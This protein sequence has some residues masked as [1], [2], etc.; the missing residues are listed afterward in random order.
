MESWDVCNITY[1]E[2]GR[3]SRRIKNETTLVVALH[4]IIISSRKERKS[5]NW[6]DDIGRKRAKNITEIKE[7]YSIHG[8]W[9]RNN[10]DNEAEVECIVKVFFSRFAL[11]HS[12]QL[13]VNIMSGA[14]ICY[15]IIA[16]ISCAISQSNRDTKKLSSLWWNGIVYSRRQEKNRINFVGQ[17]E[18][19]GESKGEKDG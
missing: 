4:R 17:R 10:E 7:S 13:N 16:I 9:L 18:K 5:L 6:C 11:P 2:S 1:Y 14:L 15:Q 19:A 8:Y 3:K 12:Q